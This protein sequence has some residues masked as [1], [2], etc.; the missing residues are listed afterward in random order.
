[1]WCPEGKGD[2]CECEREVAE[3]YKKLCGIGSSDEEEKGGGNPRRGANVSPEENPESQYHL[4]EAEGVEHDLG[5][6]GY[7]CKGPSGNVPN[8]GSGIGERREWGVQ[9]GERD[10]A[11]EEVRGEWARI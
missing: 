7:E 6:D 11:A 8:P 5:I 3:E 1:M 9:K 2:G 4:D 10:G